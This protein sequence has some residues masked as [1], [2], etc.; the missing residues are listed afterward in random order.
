[1]NASIR[2]KI[3]SS[4]RSMNV[5]FRSEVYNRLKENV[6]NGEI[7]KL[8]NSLLIK[9]FDENNIEQERIKQSLIRATKSRRESSDFQSMNENISSSV[10][11]DF[12]KKNKSDN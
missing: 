12:K 4:G 11:D 8:L 10:L 3:N 9:H 6:P 2:E 7:S 1:M 5:Y